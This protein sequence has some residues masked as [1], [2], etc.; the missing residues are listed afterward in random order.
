MNKTQGLR[1]KAGKILFYIYLIVSVG[2]GIFIS[3]MNLDFP[4]SLRNTP[5][6]NPGV[7]MHVMIIFPMIAALI[8]SAIVSGYQYIKHV[9]TF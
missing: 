9:E 3:I 5:D 6:P 2:L 8:I 7:G 4:I 1:N